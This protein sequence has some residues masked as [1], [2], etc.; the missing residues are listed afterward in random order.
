VRCLETPG[1][2]QLGEPARLPFTIG[3]VHEIV[4]A[5]TI[6]ITDQDVAY[7]PSMWSPVT[8]IGEL[9]AIAE[10]SSPAS[11]GVLPAVAQIGHV[12]SPI[13]VEVAQHQLLGR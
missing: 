13:A 12:V 7:R 11:V 4:G 8:W 9:G 3:A 5:V 6:D 10:M 1:R 2:G